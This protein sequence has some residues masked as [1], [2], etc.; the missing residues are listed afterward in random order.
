MRHSDF[1]QRFPREAQIK[2]VL[3]LGLL[4]GL[5]SACGGGGGGS[6]SSASPAPVPE[7]TNPEPEPIALAVI[8]GIPLAGVNNFDPQHSEFSF[9][10]LGHSDLTMS[11]TG[12]CNTLTGTTVRRELFDLSTPDF[13]QILDHKLRCDFLE[14][15]QYTIDADGTRSNDAA[16]RATH[17]FA[18]GLP[19]TPGINIID[20]F[21]LPRSF[22]DDMFLGYIEGA[23]LSELDLPPAIEALVLGIL[24]ELAEDNWGNLVNPDALYHVAS[25]R[26]SYLST[27]PSGEP[28]AELTGLITFPAVTQEFTPRDRMIVLTHATGSTPGDL[29]LN[30]AWYI[31]ANLFASR[32][33]LVIAPDNYGRG[34]TEGNPETYLMANRTAHNARDMITQ[35]L[36]DTAYDEVYAGTDITIIGYSQGG[37]SAIGLWQ[38]LE[39]QGT[40]A[41]STR[42]VYAGGAP[43]NL[44]QTFRGVLQHLDGQCNNGEYCRHVD[45]DITVPFATD[46]I[47]PGF[48]SYTDTGLM[49]TDIINGNEIDPDFISG[50]LADEPPYDKLKALLQLS[51][52]TDISSTAE[53]LRGTD[54]L[55][56]L[57]H[58]EF[59]RLVP[60]ANTE[61][62]NA[63][64]AAHVTV[65]FHRNRCN[66]DGYEIIYNL[67]DKVGVL[68]TLCGLAVLD[69]AMEDLK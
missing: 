12:D 18:T 55:V 1:N 65:N 2:R 61:E 48:L 17:Q 53:N 14:N 62:L 41:I 39:N 34:G 16:F 15:T 60:P 24:V 22:V 63:N 27:D 59:D 3:L 8:D 29:E 44:Y 25:Q 7:P 58:S 32:G 52:F 10:H 43:H 67:T 47:L 33:Y 26:V 28:E 11:F 56:H 50:F 40:N 21:A 30:D 37:H 68:H 36:D 35:V 66:A 64:L 49:P 45:S 69:D 23:L 9:V 4:L 31:L 5:L 42:E 51:S 57:Y 13:N 54:A 46:R 19:N 6:S 38:L 20:Q